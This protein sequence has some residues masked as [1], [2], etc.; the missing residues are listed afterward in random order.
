MT[1]CL[2]CCGCSRYPLLMGGATA[3]LTVGCL[4]GGIAVTVKAPDTT[5]THAVSIALYSLSAAFCCL[6]SC[7]TSLIGY[8]S[9][10]ADLNDGAQAIVPE[11]DELEEALR[12]KMAYNKTRP[13]RHGRAR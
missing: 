10:R 11:A 5:V 3:L 13:F 4:A 12:Q 7:A 6:G 8:V 9:K 2:N 1:G